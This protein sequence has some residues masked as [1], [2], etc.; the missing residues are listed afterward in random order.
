MSC[1]FDF[2]DFIKE[3]DSNANRDKIVKAIIKNNNR[4]LFISK[5]FFIEDETYFMDA[6]TDRTDCLT[7]GWLQWCIECES[8]D[9]CWGNGCFDDTTM[10]GDCEVI[11]F[12]EEKCFCI[13]DIVMKEDVVYLYC[14]ED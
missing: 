3:N 7:L 2:V 12:Y 14:E 11:V 6:T 9:E 1:V 10:F 8:E 4:E 5:E 13:E